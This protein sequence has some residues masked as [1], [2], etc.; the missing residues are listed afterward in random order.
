MHVCYSATARNSFWN[1]L[2]SLNIQKQS[3]IH[4]TEAQNMGRCCRYPVTKRNHGCPKF[5]HTLF[6]KNYI[7]Y[8]FLPIYYWILCGSLLWSAGDFQVHCLQYST[9]EMN[10]GPYVI[11]IIKCLSKININIVKVPFFCECCELHAAP[12]S[13]RCERTWQRYCCW[14]LL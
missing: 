1:K 13:D 12:S 3:I 11:K 7:S 14:S 10:R 9:S 6:H 2:Y 8:I 5:L 4:S